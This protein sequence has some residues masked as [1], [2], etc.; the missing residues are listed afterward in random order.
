MEVRDPVATLLNCAN[1]K[2]LPYAFSISPMFPKSGIVERWSPHGRWRPPKARGNNLKLIP[3]HFYYDGNTTAVQEVLPDVEEHRTYSVYYDR[4]IFWTV[5]YDATEKQVSDGKESNPPEDT[6]EENQQRHGFS[7]QS[8]AN[9]QKSDSSRDSEDEDEETDDWAPLKFDHRERDLLSYAG[10]HQPFSR[11]QIRRRDQ[12]WAQKLLTDSCS[13][14]GIT[15]DR[16]HGGL[17]GELPLLIAL[18]AFAIPAG[19]LGRGLCRVLGRSW[20]APLFERAAGCKSMTQIS[21][22]FE[23]S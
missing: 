14:Q 11:L 1:T 8:A 18:M 20:A 15:D 12:N 17:I 16:N 10:R 5:D 6:P 9:P 3:V 13:A 21:K 23:V 7:R 19:D 4:A 22:H 2:E